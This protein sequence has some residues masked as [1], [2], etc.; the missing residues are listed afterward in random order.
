MLTMA[1]V[2]IMITIFFFVI[3]ILLIPLFFLCFLV[4]VIFRRGDTGKSF[5]DGIF[6]YFLLLSIC[7]TED[8]HVMS[9]FC[10]LCI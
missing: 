1:S 5:M 3:F 6:F 7:S 4:L 9:V 8:A 10:D 2:H